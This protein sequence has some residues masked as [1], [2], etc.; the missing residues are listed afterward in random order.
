MMIALKLARATAGTPNMDDWTDICG[1][2]ALAAQ[3][4]HDQATP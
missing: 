2:S 1:Y 3:I 4:D